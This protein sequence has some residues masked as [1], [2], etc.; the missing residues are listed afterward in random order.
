MWRPHFSHMSEINN[1]VLQLC[2]MLASATPLAA[3]LSAELRRGD[4][5][6]PDAAAAAGYASLW[7]TSLRL[8]RDFQVSFLHPPTHFSHM[9]HPTFPISHLLFLF[10][11]SSAANSSVCSASTTSAASSL[12]SS[13][14]RWT[15]GEDSLQD[16]QTSQAR[17]ET[18]DE[19]DLKR[20]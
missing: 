1:P 9:S 18:I 3:A 17:D 6:D 10:F 4:A 16:G 7:P 14:S 2:R 11:R 15:S 12:P 5:F 20:I 19:T 8:Q 13:S